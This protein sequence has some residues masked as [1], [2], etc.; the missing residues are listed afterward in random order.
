ML[1]V[2]GAVNKAAYAA[3]VSV[4]VPVP[5]KANCPAVN[6]VVADAE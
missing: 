5:V 6:V 3:E 1:P 4:H 2:A